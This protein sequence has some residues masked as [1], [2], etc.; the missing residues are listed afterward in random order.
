MKNLRNHILYRK[1]Q[2][3]EGYSEVQDNSSERAKKNPL[4]V[5]KMI[6]ASY[7]LFTYA[8]GIKGH[9]EKLGASQ[10]MLVFVHRKTSSMS[11]STAI[12]P[13]I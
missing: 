9:L 3:K 1:R 10:T 11:N 6:G 8:T 2:S 4:Y 5:E 12:A 7:H 13:S